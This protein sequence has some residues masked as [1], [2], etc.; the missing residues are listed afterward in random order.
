MPHPS[1]RSKRPDGG[2][3]GVLLAPLEQCLERRTERATLVC[4]QVLRAWRVIRVVPSLHHLV[5]FQLLQSQRK[6][7]RADG[8][9]GLLEVLELAGALQKKLA[10]NQ[11]RPALAN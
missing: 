10:Q 5:S 8:W 4:Q 6:R 3:A 11:D 9:Q 7:I 1:S 2:S